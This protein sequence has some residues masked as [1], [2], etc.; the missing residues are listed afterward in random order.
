MKVEVKEIQPIRVAFV[1]HVGPYNQCGTA[2]EKLCAWAGPKGYFQ[3][4]VQFI[5]LT[6]DDPEVTE[7]DKIRY[8]A[9]IT[10]DESCRPEGDIG[11]QCIEGGLYAM[12]THH[13]SYSK[14]NHTY[15]ALCGRWIPQ[16]GY[17]IRSL[18]GFEVYLNDPNST[19]EAELLTDIHVPIERK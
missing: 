6:Y 15:A 2:W 13:G 18:P 4:G 12:T 8:D 1:R 3:P 14:M 11:V 7:P 16:Q 9:C 17:E 5:G 10:V 19:P